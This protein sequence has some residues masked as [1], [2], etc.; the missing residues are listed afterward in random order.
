LIKQD[1]V[2]CAFGKV[3]KSIHPDEDIVKITL[4][5]TLTIYFKNNV[6]RKFFHEK[7]NLITLIRRKMFNKIVKAL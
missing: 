7:F 4:P 1:L 6:V 2:N 3:K 5:E